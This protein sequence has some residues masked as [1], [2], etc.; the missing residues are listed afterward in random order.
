MFYPILIILILGIG[1]ILW[2]QKKEKVAPQTKLNKKIVQNKWLD[3]EEY[4]KSGGNDNLR[5]AVLE[6]DKLFDFCL[7]AITGKN[8]ISMAERLKITQKKF[9]NWQVY[10]EV[11]EAHKLRNRLV[12]E[13]EGMTFETEAKK[14]IEKFKKGLIALNML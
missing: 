9:P 11:W 7:K 3:I 12:H 1:L 14:A 8:N 4:L 2:I 10:Q 5:L 6:A 13:L